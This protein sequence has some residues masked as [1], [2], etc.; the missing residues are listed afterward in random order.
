MVYNTEGQQVGSG[1]V[2]AVEGAGHL[3][4]E[5]ST[6]GMAGG[7]YVARVKASDSVALRPF[8]LVR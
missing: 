3:D 4:L 5:I 6:E 1:R 7:L 2:V 8:A